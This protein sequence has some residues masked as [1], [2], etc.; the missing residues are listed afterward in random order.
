MQISASLVE[1]LDWLRQNDQL[2][3]IKRLHRHNGNANPGPEVRHNTDQIYQKYQFG[4]KMFSIALY[5]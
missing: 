2:P 5:L 3:G 4:I 1:I